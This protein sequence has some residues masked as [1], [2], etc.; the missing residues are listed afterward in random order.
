MQTTSLQ[1]RKADAA[2]ML[3]TGKVYVI[4]TTVRRQG[5]KQQGG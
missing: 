4:T 1:S 3:A 2:S 5:E